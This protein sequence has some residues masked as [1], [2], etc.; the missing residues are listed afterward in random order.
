[1]IIGHHRQLQYLKNLAKTGNT[2][3]AL[4]FWGQEQLGKR[5]IALEFAKLLNCQTGD[6]IGLPLLGCQMCPACREIERGIYPDLKVVAP[7]AKP[8][9]RP[10]LAR[11]IH[12]AQIREVSRF[13]C[14]KPFYKLKVVLI[15][16]AHLMTKEAQSCL[17]KTLEEPR[18]KALLILITEQPE[19]LLATVLSRVQR[20]AF[21]EISGS[22]IEKQLVSRGARESQAKA[23]SAISFGRPGR[24][25]ELFLQGEKL[26]IEQ[27]GL[28]EFLKVLGASLADR[29]QYV[30]RLLEDRSPQFRGLNSAEGNF[31]GLNSRVANL[32]PLTPLKET[33]GLWLFYFRS[34]LRNQSLKDN[35]KTSSFW[36]TKKALQLV[37]K[38]LFLL[39]STNVNPRLLLE[40]LMLELSIYRPMAK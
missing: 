29:F 33:L 34:I 23:I 8:S 20:L 16:N 1:M 17:L 27:E 15:D 12:I 25:I 22:L 14:L 38:A 18:G 11:E 31:R 40:N 6:H 37:E 30:K 5:T 19:I 39:Q 13:L 2:P 24:A 36:Q 35:F 26:K 7:L 21:F 10:S 9:A 32:T 4:L 3:H 28:K